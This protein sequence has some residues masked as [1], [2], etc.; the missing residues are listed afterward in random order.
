M[1]YFLSNRVAPSAAILGL[2]LFAF[3]A[4]N[5]LA[6][7]NRL[8]GPIQSGQRITLTGHV[9]PQARAEFDQGPTDASK[10]LE[11]SLVLRPSAEQQAALDQLLKEQQ[12]PASP[13]YH[14]WLTPD[15][16]AQRFGA[17][18]EDIA[19]IRDWLQQ[20]NLQVTSVSRARNTIHFK[21]SVAAV[22]SAFST[23]IRNYLVNGE[24]HFANATNPSLPAD[25]DLMVTSIEGLDDFRLQPRGV[26]STA[27]YTSGTGH[28][29]LAPD[30]LAT[31][32]DIKP[33]YAAGIDGTGQSIVV[34]GQ[35]QV[36]LT[37]IRA[38]RAKFGLSAVDPQIVLVPGMRDPGVSSKD[39]AEADLD[40]EWSGAVARN[41][42]II[43][44]YTGSVM[45]AVQ[46]AIDQ[47]LAP[48]ISLSYGLCEPLTSGSSLRT[49]ETWAKQANA[50]G[51]TWV[52]AAGDNGGADCAGATTGSGG[53]AVDAPASVPEITAVGGTTLND[54]NGI[55]W[56]AVNGTDGASVLSY[57]PEVV[58]N[59]ST[60]N[61]P[62]AGGGGASEFYLK[63]AWQTGSGVPND[64]ARDVP[65]IALAASANNNGYLVYSGG[66][67]AVFGGTSVSTPVFAGIV[68]LLNHSIAKS[69]TPS[70][71]SGNVNPRL[72]SL[73][74]TGTSVFHDVT[75]G[76]N[77]VTITCTSSRSRNCV[78]GS[79]GY[80]AGA[81][82]DLAT[83]LGSVDAYKLVTNFASLNS[84][85]SPATASLSLAASAGSINASDNATLTATATAT[86]G[87]VPLGSV[88]FVV[89][90]AV[91][92]TSS[93][94]AGSGRSTATLA[95][96]GA[97]L[98][99][100]TNTVTAE[101]TGS[102]TYGAATASTKITVTQAASGA[103]AI[104]GFTNAAS[105]KTSYAPG[106]LMSI[107][108]SQLAPATWSASSVPLP[109]QVG[110]VSVTIAGAD[111][112]LL[113]ASPTQLNVQIPYG[114]S[115]GSPVTVIVNNNGQT[116]NG[117]VTLSSA[118][119]GIFVDSNS[120]PVPNP[121]ATRGEIVTLFITGAGAVA[122][123]IAS[124][125]APDPNTAIANLPR[126][127]QP[128]TV[129]VGGVPAMVQFEG[130][131][132]GL[133][134]VVQVNYQVPSGVPL[135]KNAVQAQV[136]NVTSQAVSLTVTQ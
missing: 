13:N 37:D 30:D 94:V 62:A 55:Y 70:S 23:Q 42:N 10:L 90:P 92:G 114:V 115:T 12:D 34:A 19:R 121:T 108:G 131:P 36:D 98:A 100:G 40:L 18:G 57:I 29:Y 41:A 69:G 61:S 74:Q 80:S 52:N 134:G 84:S 33:L 77:V 101:Y 72:Y 120:E 68:G 28:H 87:G 4:Q 119:P 132:A 81:G 91:L 124:G 48:V 5:L 110:G 128:L 73:A 83:G 66:A 102:S 130:I 17:S 105:F 43:Y 6:Q 107:F 15:Q 127:Q 89:G 51:I 35:T 123:Q 135:G 25:L 64:G 44:V 75:S 106:M 117:S 60:T 59:D 125:S 46:Y 71:G 24:L 79:F 47:N 31:I 103:P 49:F 93:L 54:V 53:L 14:K 95:V 126:P 56:S 111:A 82:Y 2:A 11:A 3:P 67:L 38:F 109:P 16:F 78:P 63:P 50:Q 104:S 136:G 97:T 116:A 26:S 96:T 45:D 129:T 76:N 22:Q 122:P 9:K 32:Y 99:I 1:Y 58:W 39:V 20:Q 118:A 86:N 112:P 133:V 7:T 21:G 27:D 85:A 8:K 113:Y 88:T 65:D